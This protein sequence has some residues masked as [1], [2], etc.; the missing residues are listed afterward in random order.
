M[1]GVNI[2]PVHKKDV[3]KASVQLEKDRIN[4]VILAFDVPVDRDAT[5]MAM[6]LGI[7]IFQADIIYHLEDQFI[8]YVDVSLRPLVALVET[9]R[10]P[11]GD[12][13]SSLGRLSL[14]AFSL[15]PSADGSLLGLSLSRDTGLQEGS[16]GG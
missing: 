12:I 16:Q 5:Q 3:T 2:G 9:G 1:A 15:C 14:L 13:V 7:R 10:V 11:S 6:S 8:K 4:A